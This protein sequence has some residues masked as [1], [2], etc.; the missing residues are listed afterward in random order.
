M[1]RIDHK[2]T[3]T[4]FPCE[5]YYVTSFRSVEGGEGPRTVTNKV[6]NRLDHVTSE[7]GTSYVGDYNKKSPT[8]ELIRLLEE[9]LVSTDIKISPPQ[10]DNG[11]D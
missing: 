8:S 9:V 4:T 1:N 11:R 6:L 10:T 3:T 5:I 2:T 7:K